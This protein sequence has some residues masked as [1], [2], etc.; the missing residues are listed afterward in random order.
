MRHFIRLSF[1]GVLML[2]VTFSELSAQEKYSSLHPKPALIWFDAEANFERFSHPDSID[3]YLNKI[4]AHGFTHAI[5][6][7][8]PITGEVLFNSQ[9]APRMRDWNGYKRPD[10][11]YLGYF[12]K[13]GHQLG[14]QIHASLNVFVGGHNFFDRGQTYTDHPEWASMVY[15]PEKGIV[16][17]MTE[18]HKYS[19]MINPIHPGFQA[20]I[21]NVLKELV[22]T[23][24]DLDGLMLDRVRYD[25]IGAD[26]SDLSKRTFEAYIG[27]KLTHFPEDIFK[28]EK[29][30]ETKKTYHVKRGKFFLKW[31]EWR[32]K[33]ITDFMALA[34]KEVKAVNP[35]VSFGTYTGAWYP[36]YYEVGVNFA[37]RHYDPSMDFD[38][39][40][41]EYKNYGYAELL[42]L[43]TTGNYY[44]DITIKEALRNKKS[45]WNETD[46][47]AHQ[48]TWYS[49]EG[50]CEKLRTILKGNKFIGGILVDQ[51]YNDPFKLS[52]TIE[53]NL[54]KSDGLMVFDI[55]HIIQKNLWK[56]VEAGM[57]AGGQLPVKVTN[58]PKLMWLDCSANFKRFSYPD[59]IRYYVDKC[60][61]AGITHLVLDIKDNSGEVLYPSRYALHKKNWKGFDRPD[62]DFIN[63]FINAARARHLKIFAALNVFSDGQGIF[64]RGYVYDKHKKWQGVNYVPGKGLVPMT[65]IPNKGSLF[66]NP[67]LKAVQNYELDVIRETVTN[68]AFD[69]II[70]DRARYDCIDSDFSPESKKL[71]EKYIGKKLKRYPEDIY[72]WRPNNKGSFDRV[73]GEYY[74]QWIEWRA[75]VIYQFMKDARSVVKTARPNCLFGAYTGAWYPTY[76]EVGVNWAS[77]T[78]DVSKDFSWATPNYKNYG[79]AELLDFYTNGNYYWNVTLAEYRASN[80]VH[81]NETDSQ[82][83]SGEHLCVEGGCKYSKQLLKGAVPV[84][85]GLYVE[86]Y[87]KDE[88]QFKNAVEMNLKASDGVMIFDIVHIIQN[89]WWNEL[90]EAIDASSA[91]E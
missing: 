6:D 65:E 88:V 14:L 20:H 67:A 60:A 41:K 4:K 30:G 46:S 55:V 2:F 82:L 32:T 64:K 40:T 23:Y 87:K 49:V 11:D 43:Y 15:T 28:W 31:I 86:D 79:F 5:V 10:F 78:Y 54:K 57:I 1:I 8:R 12:I 76:F 53:M 48:G 85:G 7:V 75:S 24:P 74:H 58:K 63:T 16:S 19:A 9:Y 68:Y 25:G 59:S 29:D 69:G 26:F 56:E 91:Y 62:F 70:L 47:R 81:K 13:K 89:N 71:F 34:R 21:L 37:S 39:A 42:D 3:F 90:K 45:V 83:S 22:Q 73:A 33:M 51:F 52:K 66:L 27:Q 84:C 50:S 17:I 36:S 72:E 80:G 18:K 35:N 38:W 77:R 61:D 44:T